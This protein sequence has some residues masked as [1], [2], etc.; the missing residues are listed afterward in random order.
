MEAIPYCIPVES[1]SCVCEGS[2]LK[3]NCTPTH[4]ILSMLTTANH[5]FGNN[6]F[7]ISMMLADKCA[8]KS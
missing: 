1:Q 2:G 4:V 6:F 8:G 5:N 3:T 7:F